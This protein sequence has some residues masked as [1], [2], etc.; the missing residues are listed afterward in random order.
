MPIASWVSFEDGA[1]ENTLP[2]GFDATAAERAIAHEMELVRGAID[3]VAFD[4][5][6]RITL[7]GLSF[8]E[9]ILPWAIR[10]ARQSLVRLEPIWRL[11]GGCDLLVYA[12][13]E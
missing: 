5:E 6:S 3:M 10:S 12:D 4:P 1:M 9:S 2:I 11:G 8:G 13:D 7:G